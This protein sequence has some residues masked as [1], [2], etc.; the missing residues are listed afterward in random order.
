MQLTAPELPLDLVLV[1]AS[2]VL[3]LSC[4]REFEPVVIVVAS[5]VAMPLPC[6]ACKLVWLLQMKTAVGSRKFGDGDL[7]EPVTNAQS[8]DMIC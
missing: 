2:K 7:K 5:E 4:I 6:Q 1:R 3:P 8:V